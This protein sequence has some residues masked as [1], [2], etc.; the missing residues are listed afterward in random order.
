MVEEILTRFFELTTR[1]MDPV[2][3]TQEQIAYILNISQQAVSTNLKKLREG[4]SI[5]TAPYPPQ[6]HPRRDLIIEDLERSD[7]GA[8]SLDCIDIQQH[9][10]A[11]TRLSKNKSGNRVSKGYI[12]KVADKEGYS[13]KKVSRVRKTDDDKANTKRRKL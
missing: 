5:S 1:E 10:N 12:Y 2:K 8:N 11:D 4:R 13:S 6:P 3:I 9:I 7:T